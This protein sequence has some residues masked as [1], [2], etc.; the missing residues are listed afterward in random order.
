M[1]FFVIIIVVVIVIIVIIS[2]IFVTIIT[3]ISSVISPFISG[4][5]KLCSFV[6]VRS[7]YSGAARTEPSSASTPAESHASPLAAR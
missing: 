4:A 1:V 7:C 2:T 3:E 6:A 5:P